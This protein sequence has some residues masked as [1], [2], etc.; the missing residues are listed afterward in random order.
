MTKKI[1]PSQVSAQI[2]HDIGAATDFAADL[3]EDVN[4]HNMASAL[5]SVNVGEHDLACDFIRLEKDQEEAGSLTAAL[6]RRRDELLE[7]LKK[8]EDEWEEEYG[9]SEDMDEE[10]D[11][12]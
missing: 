4:D 12:D 1:K 2:E 11:E 3:L 5:R 10:G 8:A 6:S 9:G 7:R